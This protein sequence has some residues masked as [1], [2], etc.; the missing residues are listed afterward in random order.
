MEVEGCFKGAAWGKEQPAQARLETNCYTP[1]VPRNGGF[2]R[3][4]AKSEVLKCLFFYL[5]L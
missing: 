5:K 4:I 2:Q 1:R 3:H